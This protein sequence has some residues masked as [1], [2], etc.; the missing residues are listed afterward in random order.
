MSVIPGDLKL[1]VEPAANSQEGL[2]AAAAAMQ[3]EPYEF[4]F[5]DIQMPVMDGYEAVSNML[6]AGIQTPIV[7]LRAN[8]MKSVESGI[9]VAGFS[10]C[11]VSGAVN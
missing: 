2:D 11:T 1:Y 8:A 4:I 7:A 10:H 5:M 9:I 3:V 6:T